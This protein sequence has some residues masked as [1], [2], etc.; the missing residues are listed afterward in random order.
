MGAT[1]DSMRPELRRE[2]QG[3][4]G[5]Y[6][7]EGWGIYDDTVDM[8]RAVALSDGYYG[9]WSSIVQLYQKIGKPAMIQRLD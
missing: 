8:D 4:A 6:R 1:I 7:E 3:I 2:Y 5:K 9:D